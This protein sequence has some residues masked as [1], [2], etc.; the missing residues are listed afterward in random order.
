MTSN[1]QERGFVSSD[2]K[3]IADSS[4]LNRLCGMDL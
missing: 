2:Y 1:I 4:F 3:L